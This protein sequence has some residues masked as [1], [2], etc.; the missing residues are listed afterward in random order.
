M[1]KVEELKRLGRE[2]KQ[3]HL[4]A[5]GVYSQNVENAIRAIANYAREQ[6]EK[7]NR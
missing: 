7:L 2:L 4:E 3:A 5:R 1:R 6:V